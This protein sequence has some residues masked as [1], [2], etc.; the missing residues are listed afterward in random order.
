MNISGLNRRQGTQAE[1]TEGASSSVN[2][3]QPQRGA[4]RRLQRQDAL[5]TDTRYSANQTSASP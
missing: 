2:T 3:P 1:N 4:G 5:P